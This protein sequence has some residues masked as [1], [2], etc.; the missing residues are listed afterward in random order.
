MSAVALVPYGSKKDLVQHVTHSPFVADYLL[1]KSKD[2]AYTI[3]ITYQLVKVSVGW[4]KTAVL[5]RRGA[6][7]LLIG[8]V[9]RRMRLAPRPLYATVRVPGAEERQFYLIHFIS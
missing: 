8:N 1:A 2:I 4:Q 6:L 7:S 3:R 5:V 9:G